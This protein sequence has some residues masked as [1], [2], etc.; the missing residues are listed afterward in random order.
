LYRRSILSGHNEQVEVLA[1]TFNVKTCGNGKSL[2]NPGGRSIEQTDDASPVLPQTPAELIV[3][4]DRGGV[5]AAGFDADEI[6]ATMGQRIDGLTD[7][8]E[9]P[10][11]QADAV[12]KPGDVWLCGNHRVMCG[13]STSADAVGVLMAGK[14]VDFCFTSP[15]YN[16]GK[17]VR[18]THFGGAGFYVDSS[19]DDLSGGEY[20]DFNRQILAALVSVAADNFTCC[21]NVNYNKNSPGE[22][23]DVIHA[24]KEY[25]PLVETIVW[26]KH[27]APAI[28]ANPAH[29]AYFYCFDNA[30]PDSICAFQRYASAEAAQ[31]FLKTSSY[32]AYLREVERLLSGAPQFTTLTPVWSK[33]G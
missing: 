26:E 10:E 25:L 22:Y 29:I 16:G 3:R 20:V 21:Y 17:G 33:G 4:R 15:P 28:S 30:D 2:T 7:P 23:V 1:K 12:S 6:N 13:D 14:R 18:G 31:V 27:M 9:A 5:V 11:P 8:D 24:A 19:A 32:L